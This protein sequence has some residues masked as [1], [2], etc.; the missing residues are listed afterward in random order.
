MN[1]QLRLN[2]ILP[3]VLFAVLATGVGLFTLT[4]GR[5]SSTRG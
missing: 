3:I 1:S 4:R 2:V 5:R